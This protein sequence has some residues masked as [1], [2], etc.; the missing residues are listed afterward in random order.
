MDSIGD[1]MTRPAATQ[2]TVCMRNGYL[3]LSIGNELGCKYDGKSVPV[4]YLQ[5]AE[6]LD[7]MQKAISAHTK[8]TKEVTITSQNLERK[9]DMVV[10]KFSLVKC[11]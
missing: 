4:S 10:V 11:S 5:N 2:A 9:P 8:Y 1:F 6:K 7:L 3:F